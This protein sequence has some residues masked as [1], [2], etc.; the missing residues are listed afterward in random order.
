MK[1]KA[2][3]NVASDTAEEKQSYT[4][5]INRMIHRLRQYLLC[6]LSNIHRLYL[7]VSLQISW[8]DN[9]IEVGFGRVVGDQL[10][11]A[12]YDEGGHSVSSVGVSS[13]TDSPGKWTFTNFDRMCFC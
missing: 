13:W 5:L 1:L 3:K 2:V 11:M 10:F 8:A 6:T 12:Y 4:S 7:S 9:Q